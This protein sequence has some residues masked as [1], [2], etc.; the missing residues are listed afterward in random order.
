MSVGTRGRSLAI[1]SAFLVLTAFGAVT[2]Q[3]QS[4]AATTLVVWPIGDSITHGVSANH[5]DVRG[6]YR[7]PLARGLLGRG[8]RVHYVGTTTA[9]PA[10]G[11]AA[12]G[13]RHDG[14]SG[15][16]TADVLAQLPGWSVP[17][18]DVVVLALGTNDL[19]QQSTPEGTVFRL[20][21]LVM[22][23][24]ERFPAATVVV[25]AIVPT[26]AAGRCDVTTR[27]YGGLVRELVREQSLLGR[28]VELADVWASYTSG[29]CTNRGGLL[30]RDRIHPTAAGYTVMGAVL[31]D[32]LARVAVAR[33]TLKP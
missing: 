17:T 4:A 25:T 16:R 5:R 13:Q 6:G 24:T 20:G 22:M 31:T 18:P 8:V 15:W 26:G 30:S 2:A 19:R 9:N 1:A 11:L 32:V 23:L 21:Q 14:H 29:G 7:L 12:F 27:E 33:R 28:R 10:P 3:R